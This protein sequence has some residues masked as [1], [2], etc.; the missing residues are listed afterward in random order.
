M[1][2][3]GTCVILLNMIKNYD[4]TNASYFNINQCYD[5]EFKPNHISPAK[6]HAHPGFE[7]MYVAHGNCRV[8]F[9]D[10]ADDEFTVRES[11]FLSLGDFIFLESNDAHLLSVSENGA[12]ILNTQVSPLSNPSFPFQKSFEKWLSRDALIGDFFRSDPKTFR[13]YD[14]GRVC[15]SLSL[16]IK[17][18]V[19][20]NLPSSVL[21]DCLKVM[22]ADIAVQYEQRNRLYGVNTHIKRAIFEIENNLANVDVEKISSKIGISRSY[23]QQ[24]FKQCCGKSVGQYITEQKILRACN[25]FGSLSNASIADI[26]RELGYSRIAFERAFKHIMDMTPGQYLQ[27]IKSGSNKWVKYNPERGYFDFKATQPPK[28]NGTKV[29]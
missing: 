29:N 4:F 5:R 24:Q 21:E 7:I 18:Y 13:L 26:A 12:R 16:L 1:T 9:F 10:K 27:K 25:Y 3:W 22:L 14:D 17:R 15:E 20:K 23:L 28:M 8:D 19:D 11:Y 2:F 6:I